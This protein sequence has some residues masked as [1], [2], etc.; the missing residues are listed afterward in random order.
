MTKNEAMQIAVDSLEYDRETGHLTWIKPV[1]ARL[2][3]VGKR[4]GS[5]YQDGYRYIRV[6]GFRL[7]EH[8]V[9][10]ALSD[11]PA[12]VQID[13]INGIKDDNRL[14]N[15]RMATNSQNSMNKP[16]QSN[17]TSGYKGV[18]F[19]KGTGKYHAKI[20]SKGKN[21]SLGYF[22]TAEQAHA[23]YVEASSNVHGEFANSGSKG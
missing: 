19:H 6:K 17:N 15:L 21:K 23:A 7:L 5:K 3:F 14:C 13:H 9:I 16:K 10:W 12:T 2:D 20:G 8:R 18:T 22:D 4:A 11:M 1:G